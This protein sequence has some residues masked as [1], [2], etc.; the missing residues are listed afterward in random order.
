LRSVSAL[1]KAGLTTPV[2]YTI[3]DG[4]GTHAVQMPI[5]TT[6]LEEFGKA[7]AA[8]IDDMQSAGLADRVCVMGFSEFGRR[9]AENSSSGTDHGTSGPVFLAGQR[10]QGGLIGNTPSLLDL[11][12][13]DL[14]TSI[15]FR[16][17]YRELLAN[18]MNTRTDGI[19]GPASANPLRLF[20]LWATKRLSE[21]IHGSSSSDISIFDDEGNLRLTRLDCDMTTRRL[22]QW[23]MAA[24]P[25]GRSGLVL[26]LRG[27]GVHHVGVMFAFQRRGILLDLAPSLADFDHSAIARRN[28]MW[29][30]LKKILGYKPCGLGVWSPVRSVGRKQTALQQAIA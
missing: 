29:R 22:I 9:V 10:V 2:H 7:I 13:G 23:C 1:I 26:G 8:F 4:Y 6:L 28:W 16:D 18:W 3:Q 5:H 24:I 17:V 14:R 12:D 27:A 25:N 19:L 11:D 30:E 15:D 20:K 21:G